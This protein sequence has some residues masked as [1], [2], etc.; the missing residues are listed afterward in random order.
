MTFQEFL[1]IANDIVADDEF[2]K[3]N[4]LVDSDNTRRLYN[5]WC[6]SEERA[7]WTDE[8]RVREVLG[9]HGYI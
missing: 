9:N 7:E 1:K 6:L 3:P 5:F 8:L 2:Y 4:G